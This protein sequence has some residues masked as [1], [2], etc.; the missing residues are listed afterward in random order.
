MITLQEIINIEQP[1]QLDKKEEVMYSVEI[2]TK[3]NFEMRD[4]IEMTKYGY[5]NQL[6]AQLTAYFEDQKNTDSFV[7]LKDGHSIKIS[8]IVHLKVEKGF[9][10]YSL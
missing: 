2:R 8:E 5:E 4:S 6:Q 10:S 7:L 1:E 9:Q 3:Q